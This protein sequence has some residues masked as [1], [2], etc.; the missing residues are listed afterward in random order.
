MAARYKGPDRGTEHKRVNGSAV[1]SNTQNERYEVHVR[2]RECDAPFSFWKWTH[3][4][5]ADQPDLKVCAH[6]AALKWAAQ[7]N[8]PVS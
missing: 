7:G 1:G 6:C 2:C 4:K 5:R 3:R 8:R